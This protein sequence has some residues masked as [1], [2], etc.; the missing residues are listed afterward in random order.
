MK[1]LLTPAVGRTLSINGLTLTGG[2]DYLL[3]YKD[4]AYLNGLVS[5]GKLTILTQAGSPEAFEVPDEAV[6]E[7]LDEIYRGQR[8]SKP[9]VPDEETF[10]EYVAN[11]Y[12]FAVEA[13]TAELENGGEEGEDEAAGDTGQVQE[14]PLTAAQKRALAAKE[15]AEKEAAAENKPAE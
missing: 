8:A 9:W 4:D 7:T 13:Y 12:R 6:R 5:Q 14:K 15:A 3:G 2:R 1:R 10:E 11:T